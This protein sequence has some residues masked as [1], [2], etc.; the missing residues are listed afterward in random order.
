MSFQKI[1][2]KLLSSMREEIKK[3]E[4]LY[5]I[6]NDIIHPIVTRVIEQLYGYFIGFGLIMAFMVLSIVVI[7]L[8]NLKISYF[9]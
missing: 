8:L 2:E 7:L 9:K 6:T 5:I 1:T 3:E 4:N